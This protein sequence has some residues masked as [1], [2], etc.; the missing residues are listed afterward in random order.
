M[1]LNF[2]RANNELSNE[3]NIF[4]KL[5]LFSAGGEI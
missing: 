1:F 4:K 5:E 3:D 2:D